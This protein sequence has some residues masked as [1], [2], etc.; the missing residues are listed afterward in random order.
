MNKK[1]ILLSLL[2][3]VGIL[4]VGQMVSA[5]TPVLSASPATLNSVVGTSFNV[6][7]LVNPENNKV[8]AVRGTINF[9]GL[10]CQNITVASGVMAVT[11]PTCANPTFLVGIPKCT[12]N[13]QNLFSVAVKGNKVGVST[14]AFTTVRI[15]GAGDG[16][17]SVWQGGAYNI[18]AVAKPVVR[19]TPA[20]TERATTE[21]V[22]STPTTPVAT[23]EATN[24]VDETNLNNA[25][26]TG[27]AA[28]ALSGTST[29]W[30]NYFLIAL[31][32]LVVIY[33]IYYI[34]SKRKK[35]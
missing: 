21:V 11:T 1:I 6:S 10:D 22:Q 32:L 17:S 25:I 19:A 34:I 9:N 27:S 30:F 28:A 31:I 35:K 4:G 5:A 26:P 24:P 8:C 12:T 3:I 2:T 29:N 14:L 13:V 23:T 15:M 7:V 18:T 33:G 16:V 20:A